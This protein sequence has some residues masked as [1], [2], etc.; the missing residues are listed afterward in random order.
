MVDSLGFCGFGMDC[1][2][3]QGA[4]AAPITAMLAI[5]VKAAAFPSH[6]RRAAK[7]TIVFRVLTK[8]KAAHNL[9]RPQ[10]TSSHSQ[11][12]QLVERKS[13]MT[14]TRGNY[15]GTCTNEESAVSI[16]RCRQDGWGNSAEGIPPE[17]TFSEAGNN[18]GQPHAWIW[19]RPSRGARTWSF[20][21][22]K[23]SVK[24]GLQN[25]QKL[26]DSRV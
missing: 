12:R 14:T 1:L 23:S 19:N 16:A 6:G 18:S 21:I 22:Q 9:S 2:N 5:V 25:E 24:S 20:P 17:V 4:G 7:L 15:E 11:A 3:H 10:T 8:S 26:T 13:V